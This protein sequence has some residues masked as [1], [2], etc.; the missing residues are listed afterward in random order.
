MNGVSRIKI[1]WNQLIPPARIETIFSGI[2]L[3]QHGV[4]TV[5][6]VAIDFGIKEL[7]LETKRLIITA[8]IIHWSPSSAPLACPAI[9]KI[10]KS[11]GTAANSPAVDRCLHSGLFYNNRNPFL[12]HRFPG[13]FSDGRDSIP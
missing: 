7:K 5:M 4:Q 3:L 2:F 11:Q 10:W 6:L 13:W 9:C 8:V 1:V 12:Y